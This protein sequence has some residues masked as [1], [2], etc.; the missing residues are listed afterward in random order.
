MSLTSGFGSQNSERDLLRK[1]RRRKG[2]E[3]VD[4][5]KEDDKKRQSDD[6]LR[7][8]LRDVTSQSLDSV[9]RNPNENDSFGVE[10]VIREYNEVNA[11]QYDNKSGIDGL[12]KE[13]PQPVEGTNQSLDMVSRKRK[14]N[15][16]N[17]YGIQ[18]MK[19]MQEAFQMRGM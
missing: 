16:L 9:F 10:G 18:G 12:F 6:F 15:E 4:P 3:N 7:Y 1:N 2:D 19:G 11:T 14:R 17:D 8:K 13:H 5:N